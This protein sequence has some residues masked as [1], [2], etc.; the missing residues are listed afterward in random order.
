MHGARW[1]AIDPA[2]SS[3]VYVDTRGVGLNRSKD[4]GQ[5]WSPLTVLNNTSFAALASKST[6]GGQ[7]FTQHRSD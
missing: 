5:T 3:T 7:P 2:K 1:L 4:G 6:D